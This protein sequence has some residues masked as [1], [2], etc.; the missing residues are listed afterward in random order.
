MA[1]SQY[2]VPTVWLWT[3]PQYLMGRAQ[4][5]IGFEAF[6]RLYEDENLKKNSDYGLECMERCT[7]Y[8]AEIAPETC[9][10]RS[11][12]C[13]EAE[14]NTTHALVF[15]S[16]W[17]VWSSYLPI[18][19][20]WRP[21]MKFLAMAHWV[22][23]QADI[24]ILELL[25]MMAWSFWRRWNKWVHDNTL[26]ETRMSIVRALSLH[27]DYEESLPL[28]S[29]LLRQQGSWKRSPEEYMKLNVDGALFLIKTRGELGWSFEMQMERLE[30]QQAYLG[31]VFGTQKWWN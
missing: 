16:I 21:R 14:E 2:K 18:I 4:I 24:E 26:C 9:H 23:E 15:P 27:K 17:E 5:L 28:T 3:T 22:K 10:G 30:W 7:S 8:R 29:T 19:H 1:T 25:I 31:K 11:D 12:V 6:G 13:K 20:T